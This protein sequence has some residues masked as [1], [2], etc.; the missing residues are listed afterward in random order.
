MARR[1][2]LPTEE[3]RNLT[4]ADAGLQI[5]AAGDNEPPAF[6]GHAAVFNTR[7]A[8][9]PVP[10]WGFLEE[11]APGA[12]T[13]TLK[14][15]D[16]RMLIDHDPSK[17]VSR[18]SAGTLSLAEDKAGLATESELDPELSYVRDLTANLRNGNVTGMS[19]GFQ[20]VKDDWTTEE[21]DVEGLDDPAEVEVRTIRE[22][23]LIEVSAVTFPAYTATDAGLRFGVMPALARRGDVEAIARRAADRP[24]LQELLPHLP[25][26]EGKRRT[27]SRDEVERL[28][29]AYALSVERKPA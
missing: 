16:A 8:I 18:V 4:L 25:A 27:L 28:Y 26:R 7:T 5:R 11:I 14:E 20:V 15:G 13:K 9:G 29:G 24:E 1:A 17:V 21:L 2:S 23:R 22:V 3:R 10:G 12:F 19:F 6:T